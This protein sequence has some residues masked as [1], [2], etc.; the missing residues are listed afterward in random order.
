MKAYVVGTCDI[1]GA[2]LAYVQ[3]L[4]AA[5]GVAT[6]LVDLGTRGDGRAADVG[7][8]AIAPHHPD[9]AAAV[10]VDDRGRAIAA[11]A[12]AFTRFA[13]SRPGLGGIIGLG[14]SGGT[15]SVADGGALGWRPCAIAGGAARAAR[16]ARGRRG[17][18]EVWRL[19]G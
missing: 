5:T 6:L 7:P 13:L 10:L 1:K 9:G 16:A 14:G 11:M 12:E 8:E 2:E 15:A 4:I 18:P 19:A 17:R 3:G